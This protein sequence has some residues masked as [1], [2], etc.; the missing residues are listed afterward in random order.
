[1]SAAPL[2]TSSPL[3]KRYGCLPIAAAMLVCLSGSVLA[4]DVPVPEAAPRPEATTEAEAPVPVPRPEDDD[5]ESET[6]EPAPDPSSRQME[7]NK[8]DKAEE[9]AARKLPEP[10]D[11]ACVAELARLGVVSSALDEIEGEGGCGVAH[12]FE[13]RGFSGGIDLKPAAKLDCPTALALAEWVETELKP[14]GRIAI[15]TLSG[16]EKPEG[17]AVTAIR[18]AS[19]Y[20]CRARNSQKGAKLSEHGKGR[21]VDIAGF[22]LADG[23]GVT[24]TP[25]EDDHTIAGALQTAVRKGACLHFT[26]VLG[27]GADSFHADHIHLDL[28]ERRGGYRICQ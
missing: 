26:T 25:R 4:Q 22:T 7:E 13:V 15:E 18:Q 11:S 20:I 19:S 23:T 24:V 16:D 1:M 5:F 27:P 28:A 21:A 14:A 9:E 17:K 12:P 3:A 6:P 8:E 10:V 2:K